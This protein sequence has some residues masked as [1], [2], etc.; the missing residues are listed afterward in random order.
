MIIVTGQPRCGTSM[1]MYCLSLCGVNM[2]FED[3]KK[4]EKEKKAFRNIYGFFEGQWN[5]EDGTVKCM[6]DEKF[7]MFPSPRI[8]VMTRSID[9]IIKSWEDVRKATGRKRRKKLSADE[10]KRRE[11]ARREGITNK[12]RLSLETRKKYPNIVID[13]DIF[14]NTPEAYKEDFVKL[15]PELDFNTLITGIDKHLYI[16]RRN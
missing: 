6:S 11:Q 2:S 8:I 16:D 3:G 13:Y 5:G 15:C 10:V 1:M 9:E 12:R 7:S 4:A 14:V